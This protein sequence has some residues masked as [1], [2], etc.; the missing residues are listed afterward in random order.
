MATISANFS[1]SLDGF[2]AGPDD[3]VGHLFDWYDGGATEV[4][5]PG[6]DMVSRTTRQSADLLED[7]IARAGRPGRAPPDLRLTDGWGG[8]HP[9]GVPVFVV[10]HVGAHRTGSTAHLDAPFTFVTDA[11]SRRPSRW[12]PRSPGPTAPWAWPARTSPS[13][14][15]RP[16]CSTRCAST[17]PRCCWGRGSASSSPSPPAR[18][19]R[20]PRGRRGRAGHPPPLPP[21]PL[22]PAASRRAPNGAPIRPALLAPRRLNAIPSPVGDRGGGPWEPRDGTQTYDTIR[23]GMG[24]ATQEEAA[25]RAPARSSGSTRRSSTPPSR[26]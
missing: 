24:E 16:G 11:A 23:I 26:C 1:Q 13:S 9:V 25:P 2:I 19:V 3:S 4:H 22:T 17:W 12:P 10:T 15:W 8:S 7:V 21:P 5:W 18:P 6:N 14:V 20:R